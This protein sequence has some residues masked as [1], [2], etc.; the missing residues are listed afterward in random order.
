MLSKIKKWFIEFIL[1]TLAISGC[2][3]AVPTNTSSLDKGEKAAK[4]FSLIPEG[5]FKVK[6]TVTPPGDYVETLK[7][8]AE[9]VEAAGTRS[10]TLHVPPSYDG[11]TV[12]PLV[13]LLHGA[14]DTAANF[15][16]TTGMN[17]QSDE[18]GFL[19]VYP[20]AFG[21][22]AT[23][24]AGFVPG[25]EAN[26]VAFL[27]ALVDHF[28]KD[29]SVD[30]KRVYVIGFSEGGMMANKLA[31]S[32]SDKIAGIGVVGGTT[33]YQKT[34]DSVTT[35]EPA[36]APVSVIVLHGVKDQTV[37]YETTKA[38]NK[39][40][41]G[42]LPAFSGV[43]YWLDQDKCNPKGKLIVRQNENIRMTT[44]TCETGTAVRVISVWSGT[45]VWFDPSN[46]SSNKTGPGISATG[47][48]LEFLFAQIKP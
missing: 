29:F 24:N 13:I 5:W 16:A 15:A 28:I 2:T 38:L 34:K 8:K 7:V 10:Y 35:L 12:V 27:T 39:G 19:A 11:K 14:G 17:A 25:A 6:P 20:D 37:P 46:T 30:S 36:I 4:G 26:D 3:R 42:Y 48:I 18:Q 45:H 32:I 21:N 22:P 23:W 1:I 31:A 33:G 40:T 9:T 44:Y 41:E 47:K 43:T